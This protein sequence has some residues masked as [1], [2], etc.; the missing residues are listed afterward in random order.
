VRKPQRPPEWATIISETEPQELGKLLMRLRL[1]EVMEALRSINDK[2]LHWDKIRFQ[3]MPPEMTPRQIWF[4]VQISREGQRQTLPLTFTR[5]G[6]KLSYVTTPR[7]LEWLHDIDKQAGGVVGIS[8]DG[9]IDDD[10]RYLFNS[11]MEEAIA[12][13]QL[14]GACTTRQIAKEMLRTKR[15]PLNE[16]EKMIRNNYQAILEVRDLKKDRLTPD[17]L[18]HLQK[19]L[20]RGTLQNPNAAGRFRLATE[21]INVVDERTGDVLHEPPPADQI[22]WRIR[23][24][25]DFANAV[26]E[27]FVHPIVKAA[28]L[29]FA[30]GFVHPF[31]DGNGR[32][33]RAISYWY[34][35]KRNYWLFEYLPISRVLVK[36]PVKY[37][38]AYLYAETDSG[39]LTYFIRY[40][41]QAIIRALGSFNEYIRNEVR[42]MKEAAQLLETLPGLNNRQRALIHDAIKHTSLR[43]TTRSHEGKYHVSYPTARADLLSLVELGLLRQTKRGRGSVFFPAKNLRQLLQLPSSSGKPQKESI[44]ESVAVTKPKT[45][46]CDLEEARP[47]KTGEQRSLFD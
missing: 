42:E 43:C 32:T 20:T 33:A 26:S 21:P 1:P 14:E 35:L 30:I 8:S 38:R 3:P 37:A 36:S 17:I 18:C 44:P 25:C 19:I 23:E 47:E 13:S 29:H 34:L 15:K 27:P 28:V 9:F 41:L 46:D 12:S 6:K 4:A 39:D 5:E 10:E 24:I 7:H 40:Q 45:E 16:A 11:L 31:A 2:Y 22:E